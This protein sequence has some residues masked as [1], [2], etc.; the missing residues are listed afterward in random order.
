MWNIDIFEHKIDSF[1]TENCE[2]SELT[3]MSSNFDENG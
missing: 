2:K 1:G 3:K